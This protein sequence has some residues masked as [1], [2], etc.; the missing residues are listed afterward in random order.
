[1]MPHSEKQGAACLGADR[2][3]AIFVSMM[4]Y[5]EKQGAAHRNICSMDA[6]GRQQRCSAPE[7]FVGAEHR[8][9]KI[10]FSEIMFAKAP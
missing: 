2:R 9:I 6:P 3:T 8:N 4:P 1:M 7:I 10:I 5:N